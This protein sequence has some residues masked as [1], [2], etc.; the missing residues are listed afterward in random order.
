MALTKSFPNEITI[1][2]LSFLSVDDLARA[3]RVSR[4]LQA[5]SEPLLYREAFLCPGHA[6]PSSLY[7]FIRTLLTPGRERLGSH[8][9]TL[10]IDWGGCWPTAPSGLAGEIALFTAAGSRYGIQNLRA[11]SG[12]QVV[13]CLHLL[14]FLT[15][16]DIIPSLYEY[17]F[18]AFI[19]SLHATPPTSLPLGLQ[20][21]REFNWY[22]GESD[23]GVSYT[24]LL[25]LM[26]LPCIRI[27]DLHIVEE[28]R[29]PFPEPDKKGISGLT[30]LHLSSAA[31][32]DTSLARI[33]TLPS[34]L[35]RFSFN[36]THGSDLNL[37]HLS[38]ALKPLQHS[39]QHLELGLFHGWNRSG[40]DE[41]SITK[42]ASLRDW[43]VLRSVRVAPVALLGVVKEQGLAQVLPPG[44][45][46]FGIL[47]DYFWSDEEVAD[48]VLV[49]LG[50][51]EKLLPRLR[52]LALSSG[53]RV[54][55]KLV[56]KIEVACKNVGV[57]RVGHG[58]L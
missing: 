54:N 27:I 12:A 11:S 46:A 31:I 33:L 39:L 24:M 22:S 52:R 4:D 14:P 40:I 2:I 38:T 48:M 26:R 43:P 25:T 20:S 28:L 45:C 55:L 44:L 29:G 47:G 53:I 58:E 30:N 56:E 17:D 42:L 36:A 1:A 35:T 41:L 49:M 6:Q 15:T 34:A 3:S 18:E 57:V 51:K 5:L 23:H 9:R 32:S 10:M 50:Q 16:L 8:V 21:L 13:L 19:E 37:T 7:I